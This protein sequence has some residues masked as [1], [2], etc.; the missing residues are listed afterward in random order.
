[1]SQKIN[2]D[3]LIPRADLALADNDPVGKRKDTIS[4]ADMQV[5]AFFLLNLYKPD[6]QRET[7]EWDIQKASDFVRSFLTSELIPAIILWQSKS[8]RIFVIDGAHRLSSLI[9][10]INDDYGDGSI[11]RAFYGSNISDEQLQIASKMRAHVEKEIGAYKVYLQAI[12][13]PG[14]YD[15]ATVQ[16][17]RNLSSLAIQLQWVEGDVTSAERSFFNI[18]QKASP[19][20]QTEMKIIKNRRKPIGIS[21]RA[22]INKG[23]GHKYWASFDPK[24]QNEIETIANEIFEIFFLPKLQT[25]IKTTEVP[26][27]GKYNSNAL[28]IVFDFLDICTNPL[29][30]N[31]VDSDGQLTVACLKQARKIAR[32]I[33]S[34]HASSLGLHPLIYFYSMNGSFRVASFY[35]VTALVMDMDIRNR[36]NLFIKHRTAFERIYFSSTII[37]QHL[38]RKARGAR[39]SL[40]SVRDYL[41]EVLDYLEK[42][43]AE[44]AVIIELQKTDKYKSLPLTSQ[45]PQVEEDVDFAASQKS[46]VFIRSALPHMNHCSI[47]GGYLHQNSISIDHIQRKQDGGLAE[48]ANGQVSHPYCNTGYKN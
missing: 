17:A 47:C 24:V 44:D 38:I 16:T 48:V 21:A 11:S 22:I 13:A 9:A 27:C 42:G 23:K 41:N 28:A 46:E 2:L 4:A 43:I 14:S 37:I 25:P 30:K 32:L 39:A 18:N 26:M 35:S 45:L 31:V 1:M 12:R 29:T 5:D 34:N 33:N 20:N 8:G 7:S 10:W 3:A 36:K 40:I 15:Q 6:F 19:I